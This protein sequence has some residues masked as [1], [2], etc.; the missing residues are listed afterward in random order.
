LVGRAWLSFPPLSLGPVQSAFILADSRPLLEVHDTTFDRFGR[1]RP[2]ACLVCTQPLSLWAGK[3]PLAAVHPAP[4]SYCSTRHY[5][6]GLSLERRTIFLSSFPIR[7]PS[8][9]TFTS[10]CS[11]PRRPDDSFG[12]SPEPYTLVCILPL[13]T[14]A[15]QSCLAAIHQ[16]LVPKDSIHTRPSDSLN[17]SRAPIPISGTVSFKTRGTS[18]AYRFFRTA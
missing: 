4:G 10:R 11:P 1:C 9:Q 12:S 5:L 18:L 2:T 8:V 3:Y 17:V 16:N 15:Q 6:P 14:L 13:L 7:F